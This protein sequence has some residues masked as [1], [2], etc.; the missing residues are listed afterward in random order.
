MRVSTIPLFF[1]E[2]LDC[3][4]IMWCHISCF[5]FL[6]WGSIVILICSFDDFMEYTICFYL[7]IACGLVNRNGLGKRCL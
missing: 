7:G 6:L 4:D 2:I 5:P 3:G 1:C